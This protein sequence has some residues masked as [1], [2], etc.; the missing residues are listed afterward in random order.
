MLTRPPYQ[1]S[2]SQIILVIAMMNP[3]P[4]SSSNPPNFP[5]NSFL[6]DMEC[7]LPIDQLPPELLTLVTT[8]TLHIQAYPLLLKYQT[9]ILR[10]YG[11][12]SIQPIGIH[13]KYPFIHPFYFPIQ[14]WITFLK[15]TLCFLWYLCHLYYIA[16]EFPL[17]TLL[18]TLQLFQDNYN[19]PRSFHLD[20]S[21]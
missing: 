15:E 10:R 4:S 16:I 9:R 13:P 11:D 2:P 19:K 20:P 12:T 21:H 14:H 3:S 18:K 7:N 6:M 5:S 8:D 17:H 1:L